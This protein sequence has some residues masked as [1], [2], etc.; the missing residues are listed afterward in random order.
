[1][2]IYYGKQGSLCLYY[3]GKLVSSYPLTKKK[4]F[5]RYFNQGEELIFKSK[6]IN[7]KTQIK[8]YT[9]LCNMIMN[10]KNNNQPIRRTD[11]ILFLNCLMALLRLKI[12]ENDELNG[13]M[14]FKKRKI[15]NKLYNI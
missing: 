5:Q 14:I 15:V 6:G 11:H 1:M 4:T 3:K 7:I 13:Y 2:T 10:R 12:I 8:T 9:H